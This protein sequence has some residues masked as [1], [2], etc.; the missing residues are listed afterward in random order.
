MDEP[1]YDPENITRILFRDFPGWMEASFYVVAILAIG[2]PYGA[3]VAKVFAEAIDEADHAPYQR[4]RVA[5]AGRIAGTAATSASPTGRRSRNCGA[6][7]C[8]P[9]S[10]PPRR[11]R[12]A[13]A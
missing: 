9:S 2:I 10:G 12:A 7:P 4:L 8:R 11:P 1:Q 13:R 3:V 6:L 5:G